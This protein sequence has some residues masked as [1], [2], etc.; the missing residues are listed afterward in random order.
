MANLERYNQRDMFGAQTTLANLLGPQELCT[1]IRDEIA[2]RIKDT[3]FE[4]LYKDGGRPP[5]SPRL[6]VLVTI[7]ILVVGNRHHIGQPSDQVSERVIHCQVWFHQL[8]I[9]W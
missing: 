1:T 6:L 7:R 5:V 2:P 8:A 3:D 9:F 4:D